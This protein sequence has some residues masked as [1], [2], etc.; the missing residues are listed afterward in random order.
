MTHALVAQPRFARSGWRRGW[1]RSTDGFGQ[2]L[3][4]ISHVSEGR[5][6]RGIVPKLVLRELDG[7]ARPGWRQVL[8]PTTRTPLTAG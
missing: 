2:E 8:V 3:L 6:R 1:G 5:V 7:T 4:D